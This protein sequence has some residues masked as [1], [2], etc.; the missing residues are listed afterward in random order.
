MQ[1]PEQEQELTAGYDSFLDIVTNI[2][3]I[4]IILVMVVGVRASKL[5]PASPPTENL[6]ERYARDIEELRRQ[7][8]AVES[9][10]TDVLRIHEAIR[11]VE[12]DRAAREFE[13]RN[14]AGLVAQL[15]KA[16][17]ER[18]AQAS[19]RERELMNLQTQLARSRSRADQLRREL[20]A[21]A[22]INT[23]S[24]VTLVNY[25]TPLSVPADGEELHFQI[26]NGRVAHIPL[27]R[28]LKELVAD[29]KQKIYRLLEVP[30]VSGT[31]GPLGGYRLQYVLARRNVRI[32]DPGGDGVQGAMVQLRRWVLQP[33]AD[34]GD[35]AEK[36]L[37]DTS[38]FRRRLAGY[39]PEKTIVTIWCY[40]D[41]FADF[42]RLRDYLHQEGF[43][44][45]GR[46]LPDGYPITG[47]P[48]GSKSAAQ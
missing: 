4:L 9:L 8:D 12:L 43:S 7:K 44:V 33:V 30:E 18:A 19:E 15:G 5:P 28:L 22:S 2:V 27:D 25:P 1:A 47:S 26:R 24:V 23:D 11:Q 34:V 45:A 38:E 13:R 17:Q 46:P 35:P 31:V 16:I 10:R 14:L 21:S 40:P 37:D 36:A 6:P 42:R 32:E 39:Q 48:N 20:E 29:A 41:G 3:G